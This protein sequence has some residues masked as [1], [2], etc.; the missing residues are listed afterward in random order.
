[1]PPPTMTTSASSTGKDR[2]AERSMW[3][4]PSSSR[5]HPAAGPHRFDT[6]NVT[7]TTRYASVYKERAPAACRS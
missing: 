4:D 3:A 6:V 5:S 2:H 7:P 1:M